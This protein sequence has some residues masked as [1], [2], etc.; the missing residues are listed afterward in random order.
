MIIKATHEGVL[1]IGEIQIPVAVLED[2]TRVLTQGGFLKAIGRSRTP[3]S[4]TGVTVAEMPT[5]L[6]AN[7]LKPFITNELVVSTTPIRF[8][9][10]RGQEL[11]GYK[12]ELLPEV[13]DVYLKADDS[14]ALLQSQLNIL[15]RC[16]ILIRGLAKVTVSSIKKRPSV[17]GKWTNLFI[18][19]QLPK[20]VLTELKKKTPK[21]DAGNYTAKVSPKPHRGYGQPPPYGPNQFRNPVNADS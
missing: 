17:I 9:S 21:S 15:E 8:I 14:K 20:G 4:G 16:K 13:C 11:W 1:D 19:N 10:T 18:Y 3:K 5:F 12:A 2:G 6:A 7:N